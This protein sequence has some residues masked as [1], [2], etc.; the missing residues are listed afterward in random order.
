VWAQLAAEW[1][2]RAIDRP[3]PVDV[4]PASAV[5]DAIGELG[6]AASVSALV[7]ALDARWAVAGSLAR[8]GAQVRFE[9]ELM[10]A[11]S[12]E[13]LHSL[14]PVVGP[15]DSLEA[16]VRRLAEASAAVAV[17]LLAPGNPPGVAMS[18][19][20]P[21][22]EVYRDHLLQFD[23]FCQGRLEE[24]LEVGARVLSTE[25]RYVSALQLHRATNSNLGRISAA[26]SLTRILEGLMDGM[27]TM[28]R[29]Q[30][31]WQRGIAYDDPVLERRGADEM[32]RLDPDEWGDATGRTSLGANRLTEALTRFHAYNLEGPC[33]RSWRPWWVSMAQTYH[34]LGRHTDELDLVLSGLARFPGYRPL[35][36]SELS[37][38]AAL[39]RVGAVDSLLD[40][41]GTLPPEPADGNRPLIAA[42][43]L[44]AHG[45]QVAADA[46]MQRALQWY[47]ER[48]ATDERPARGNAW[49]NAR[50]WSDADTLYA[51]L[52]GGAPEN[53]T[54]LRRRGVALARLGRREEALVMAR[55]LEA[56]HGRPNLGALHIAGQAEIA[57]SLSER[58]EAVRLL[59]RAFDAGYDYNI[60]LH[61]DP[62]YDGMR[63]YAP[64]DNLVR[65][66]P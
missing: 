13:R 60:V 55:R 5:R 20:P 46:V 14:E 61:R 27:T 42:L 43:E 37:A 6:P 4:I 56:L 63:G 59:S 1:I 53:V 26:D 33:G 31:E 34:L 17:T 12:G 3:R 19:P 23:L 50:R 38:L 2:G 64:W 9:I 28:E 47:A 40:A 41:V 49:Y 58:N 51:A 39:G 29:A 16:V 52:L 7:E 10:D 45:H 8:I 22:V 36:D 35:L 11:L 44:R 30:E 48:P 62:A 18:A 32:F 15:A 66:R 54:Y 65:P 24:S 25:P 57:A 21:S